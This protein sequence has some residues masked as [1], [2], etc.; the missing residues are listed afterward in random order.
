MPIPSDEPDL[1]TRISQALAAAA[2]GVADQ[3]PAGPW[4]AAAGVAAQMAGA[5]AKK[6]ALP[7]ILGAKTGKLPSK[8]PGMSSAR[9]GKPKK[10]FAKPLGG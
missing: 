2:A 6:R 9:A 3:Q 1:R 5:Y 8:M 7:Q 4:G 10:P